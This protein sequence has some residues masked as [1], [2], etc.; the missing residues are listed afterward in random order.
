MARWQVFDDRL[1]GWFQHP[2]RDP[3]CRDPPAC[4]PHMG[5]VCRG[6]IPPMG[7]ARE[8]PEFDIKSPLGV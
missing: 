2:A 1:S 5:F 8:R 4:G 6:S 7:T 3:V